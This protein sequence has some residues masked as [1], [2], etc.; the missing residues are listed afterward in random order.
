MIRALD[1]TSPRASRTAKE[2]SAGQC[3]W[4]KHESEAV[5]RRPMPAGTSGS[6]TLHGRGPAGVE[7][8]F[9]KSWWLR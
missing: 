3:D 4:A 2:G 8:G 1:G 5:W 9:P 6:P 7:N